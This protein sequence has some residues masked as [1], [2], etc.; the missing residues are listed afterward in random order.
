MLILL[1][2]RC[3]TVDVTNYPMRSGQLEKY[4]VGPEKATYLLPVHSWPAN[5]LDCNQAEH[6]PPPL[7]MHQMQ[8]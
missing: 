7:P 1:E 5:L 2:D 6:T 8:V 3:L 4:Q